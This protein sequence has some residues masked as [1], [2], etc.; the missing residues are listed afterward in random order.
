MSA[1][2]KSVKEIVG[3]KDLG[4]WCTR[5]Q[6]YLTINFL[7][8]AE[9]TLCIVKTKMMCIEIICVVNMMLSIPYQSVQ[10]KRGIQRLDGNRNRK[11]NLTSLSSICLCP[12]QGNN[13]FPSDHS[14]ISSRGSFARYMFVVFHHSG[15]PRNMTAC[16]L[17][18]YQ[19]P[20]SYPECKND[21]SPCYGL[22]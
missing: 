15:S 16:P 11:L 13:T 4:V 21:V 18:P 5:I 9:N 20:L 6:H 2:A 19:T 14:S 7:F 1:R 22:C 10:I 17:V 8:R 3:T 12:P